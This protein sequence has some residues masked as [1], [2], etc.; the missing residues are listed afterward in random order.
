MSPRRPRSEEYAVSR[1]DGLIARRNG[2][3]AREKLSFFD[4]YVPPA[5]QVTQAKFSSRYYVDLFAGPGVNIDDDGAEFEGA[6][7]R[8][9]KTGATAK[10]HVGFTNAVLVN[11]DELA[12]LA[13]EYR[14]NRHC[15]DGRCLIP[16]ARVKCIHRDANA[17]VTEIMRA[18]PKYSY[19]LVFADIE[20]PN[21]LPF[22]TVQAIKAQGH[23]AVDFC[24]LFPLDMAL[25]RML[26]FNRVSVEENAR[27]L[28]SFLGTERW[29]DYLAQRRTTNDN[30]ELYQAIQ[31]LYCEQLRGLDW[32]YVEE[33]RYVHRRGNA[34]LYKLLLA[35]NNEVGKKLA[36]WSAN[37]RQ[38]SL[39]F[40]DG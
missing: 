1:R 20:K 31:E 2:S 12:H 7:L 17:A 36:V 21:Q 15:E 11:V 40:G 26:S 14:V 38:M 22:T 24:V 4:D 29:R 23:T 19:L 33:T 3:W 25:V 35:T 10:P 6:A 8:V 28:T 27:A 32:K 34:R 9:L 37:R 39:D 5:I 18:I 13:L 16:T 30:P